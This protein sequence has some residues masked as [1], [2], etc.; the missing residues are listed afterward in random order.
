M[1]TGKSACGLQ[2]A[3]PLGLGEGESWTGGESWEREHREVLQGCF[4]EQMGVQR[5]RCCLVFLFLSVPPPLGLPTLLLVFTELLVSL[6]SHT[7]QHIQQLGPYLIL[8][9]EE[10]GFHNLILT[11]LNLITFNA[12]NLGIWEAEAGESLC[13]QF[14]TV[15]Q[16]YSGLQASLGYIV[17]SRPAW[18]AEQKLVLKSKTTAPNVLSKL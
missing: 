11:N 14:Y 10:L 2:A 12:H 9:S 8:S 18:I 7:K 15:S 3:G 4:L 5:Q 1:A 6:S 13:F 16:L 17:S